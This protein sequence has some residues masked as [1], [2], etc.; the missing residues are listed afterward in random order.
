[1]TKVHKQPHENVVRSDRKQKQNIL[2]TKNQRKTQK[3][4]EKNRKEHFFLF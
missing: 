2:K 3:T 4:E 1:M